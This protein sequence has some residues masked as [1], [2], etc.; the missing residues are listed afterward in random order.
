LSVT[1]LQCEIVRDAAQHRREL[2]K[3]RNP[4]I[5][6]QVL[7]VLVVV[8]KVP[9]HLVEMASKRVRV[10]VD[11]HGLGTADPLVFGHRCT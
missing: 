7:A 6:T 5:T 11:L 1:H 10:Q 3:A 2:A 9:E 4:V 8:L